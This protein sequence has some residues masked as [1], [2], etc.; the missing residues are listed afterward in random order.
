MTY[1]TLLY[2]CGIEIYIQ[3]TFLKTPALYLNPNFN[4]G[5]IWIASEVLLADWTNLPK[6]VSVKKTKV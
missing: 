6:I 4:K 2:Y 1:A 3:Y 5:Q